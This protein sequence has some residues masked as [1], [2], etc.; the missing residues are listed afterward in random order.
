MLHP[1]G[2]D[3]TR[4]FRRIHIICT[5][6]PTVKQLAGD[7]SY[8][9]LSGYVR[10]DPQFPH[11]IGYGME[12]SVYRAL[13]EWPDQRTSGINS[14]KVVVKV[15][16]GTSMK[17][18][19]QAGHLHLHRNRQD[20]DSWRTQRLNHEI[21]VWRYLKHPNITE[22]IG[23]AYLQPGKPPGL[24]SRFVLRNDF[25]TYIGRH[26][27][28]KREK[29]LDVARGLQYL[30]RNRVVHDDVRMDNVLVTDNGVAQLKGFGRSRI[31]DVRGFD[32]KIQRNVRFTAPELFPITQPSSDIYPT[33]Q[34]DIFSLAML[35]LQLFHAPDRDLQSRLP[36]NHI[37]HRNGNG[38]DFRLVRRIHEGERPIRNRYHTMYDHH[39]ALLCHCW[40]G[41]PS[42]RP[43]I[44]YVV[45]M[46]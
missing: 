25:L 29:A 41:D 26:P 27:N 20:I 16:S 45:K 3:G 31:Q 30:H 14:M 37:R 8:L 7:L 4:F 44:T 22:F 21:A 13:Y 19:E 15:I 46:L 1:E 42:A 40:N 39:W 35:L 12:S 18:V 10:R 2:S 6:D 36:Y 17:E 38:Y 5:K 34:S 43:D 9:D 24:V 23:I 28:L 32:R 33:F 11:P